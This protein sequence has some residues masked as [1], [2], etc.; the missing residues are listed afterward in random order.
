LLATGAFGAVSQHCVG[1]EDSKKPRELIVKVG[2]DTSVLLYHITDVASSN[3][4]FDINDEVL[5]L[6][7]NGFGICTEERASMGFCDAVGTFSLK[8][9][10]THHDLI[11]KFVHAGE[12]VN[13]TISEEGLYCA[14]MYQEGAELSHTE[15]I[16]KHSY[17]YLPLPLYWTRSALDLLNRLLMITY[18]AMEYIFKDE[19]EAYNGSISKDISNL[20]LAKKYQLLLNDVF[21]SIQNSLEAQ[22]VLR[23]VNFSTAIDTIYLLI[24][25]LLYYKSSDG[26][27]GFDKKN[28]EKMAQLFS[29]TSLFGMICSGIAIY[30][31]PARQLL[32]IARFYF[33]IV[34]ST[35]WIPMVYAMWNNSN[36]PKGEIE[37]PVLA[38][39]HYLSKLCLFWTP[40]TTSII[41][42]TGVI[43]IMIA[44]S[45]DSYSHSGNS[46][47]YMQTISFHSMEFSLNQNY[48]FVLLKQL[49]EFS[50]LFVEWALLLIWR[51]S[52]VRK[53]DLESILDHE[54][55][56][57]IK[58]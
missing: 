57:G 26:I 34:L 10:D 32:V 48:L 24:T 39:K 55:V 37:N 28:T 51:P 45:N 21:L 5:L 50:I 53:T 36:I 33:Q 49:P 6:E 40:L 54:I 13:L 12:K 41:S 18:V 58:G 14:V 19:N 31:H 7:P 11:N 23:L 9:D 1:F 38:K 27:F 30:F 42:F 4:P 47:N 46:S 56:E 20:I 15:L 29:K 16:E 43:V 52:R 44:S 2:S 3:I 8:F 35:V 17:G 22:G 25:F